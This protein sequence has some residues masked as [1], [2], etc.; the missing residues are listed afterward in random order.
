MGFNHRTFDALSRTLSLGSN[1]AGPN[2]FSLFTKLISARYPPKITAETPGSR[3]A[4]KRLS[5]NVLSLYSLL[6][7]GD[8]RVAALRQSWLV[9]WPLRGFATFPSPRWF[10]TISCHMTLFSAPKT[11]NLVGGTWTSQ[12]NRLYSRF[13]LT[14]P[15]ALVT[16]MSQFS[17]VA[18]LRSGSSFQPIPV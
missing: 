17:A 3:R 4:Q 1:S 13:R 8:G 10:P 12:R 7:K 15:V 9:S 14:S 11:P 18:T 2:N 5:Q 6:S 16:S